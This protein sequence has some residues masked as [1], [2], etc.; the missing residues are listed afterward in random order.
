MMKDKRIMR[1]FTLFTVILLLSAV[2]IIN[3]GKLFG[4]NFKQT[5]KVEPVQNDTISVAPDGS[6]VVNTTALGKDI[7]GFAGQVPLKVY[8]SKS[9]VITKVEALKNEETPD[10]FERASAILKQWEG[11]TVD[12][13]L[14]LQVDAVSG[15]TFSSEAI[16]GNVSAALQFVKA[17]APAEE[18]A[19][20]WTIVAVVSLLA[21]LAGAIVPLFVRKRSW[22]VA[23]LVINV[24]VL[25]LWSGTFVSYTLLLN[26]FSNGAAW[27]NIAVLAAPMVMLATAFVYPLF[28]KSNY[29]CANICPF[30]S[31]QEL[32]GLLNRRKK[33]MPRKVVS[34][35]EMFRNV[36]WAVLIVLM[37][38][39][40]STSWMDYE[41]FTAFLFSS[42]SVWV[43]VAAAVFLLLSIIIPRPY[44][45]F[46]CPTGALMRK[47]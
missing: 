24:V 19:Q 44:C 7:T 4:H 31:A 14:S 41:L 33:P 38:T 12:G 26:L 2:A 17:N 42:A 45:R 9:H 37:L 35:L 6:M 29:Y 5:E 18:S 43:L 32:M 13:A 11:K 25:G 20:P 27:R 21:A 40:I 22:H 39:G 10:F 46:V 47:F 30:G 1:A 15:A 16:K 28:G 23:Q 3:N 36:L 34:A 8:I